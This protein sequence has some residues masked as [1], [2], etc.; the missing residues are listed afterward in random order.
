MVFSG[1][2][3]CPRANVCGGGQM[4]GRVWLRLRAVT[5]SYGRRL[6]GLGCGKLTRAR[7]YADTHC[8]FCYGVFTRGDRRVDG[9]RDRSP[10]SVAC[11][12]TRCD[13]RTL[14]PARDR[15]HV[16]LHDTIV[17]AIGRA[18]GRRDRS[19]DRSP[20]RSPRVNTVL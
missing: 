20:R 8:C 5:D 10:R 4:S 3:R 14:R 7:L 15:L 13:R 11:M 19:R 18:I 1:R 12:F 17:A 2:G 9:S 6:H 16:C